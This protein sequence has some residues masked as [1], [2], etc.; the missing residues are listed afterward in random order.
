M[1]RKSGD[2]KKVILGGGAPDYE[3]PPDSVWVSYESKIGRKLSSELRDQLTVITM[4]FAMGAYGSAVTTTTLQSDIDLWKHRTQ[5]LRNKIR[6]STENTKKPKKLSRRSF[7]AQ[8]DLN[9]LRKPLTGY[10]E[11]LSFLAFILDA[12]VAAA[13]LT[14][15]EISSANYP[16]ARE[17]EMWSV[18]VALLILALRRNGIS[19]LKTDSSGKHRIES[20]FIDFVEALQ[21]TLPMER[22]R[23]RK[24]ESLKKGIQAVTKLIVD[25][26]YDALYWSLFGWSI[27]HRPSFHKE[28]IRLVR[29]DPLALQLASVVERYS[30]P[31]KERRKTG[32]DMPEKID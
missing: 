24:K 25:T 30:Q 3:F 29:N 2:G 31:V 22:Q 18:W 16:G 14:L 6:P 19:I 20:A 7:R 26:D 5:I 10:N 28:I 15:K 9:K 27:L 23:R 12:A 8:F 32:N 4:T 17:V 11:P 1:S 13:D 21:K